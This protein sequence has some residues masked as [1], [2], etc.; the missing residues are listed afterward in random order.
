M[1]K[2]PPIVVLD[3]SER[4]PEDENQICTEM[5]FLQKINESYPYIPVI[6]ITS[7]DD[8]RTKMKYLFIGASYFIVKPDIESFK[9]GISH[10][11]LDLFVEEIS[12]YIWNIIK[13][14]KLYLERKE[15][16][17]AEEEIIDY[18]LEDERFSSGSE[19]NIFNTN[20]LV[21]DDEPEIRKAIK[22]YLED[23]GFLNIDIAENGEEAIKNFEKRGHDVIIV[24]IVM[25]KKNGIEVLR[26]I[27]SISPNSQVIIITGNAD[28][29]SAIAAVKLGAFDYIEKPF[30]YDLISRVVKKA[31]EKR[32]LLNKIGLN[33]IT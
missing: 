1:M 17:F 10:P 2:I 3:L 32:L 31:L 28:K 15:M 19:K 13:T 5:D 7:I 11:D 22:S 21:V 12:Y 27:K 30:D 8:P 26:E 4:E 29:D 33:S 25:P 24:D 16:T 20:I 6:I 9:E 18:L 14:R 23:E